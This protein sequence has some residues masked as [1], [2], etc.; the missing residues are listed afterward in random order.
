MNLWMLLGIVADIRQL[1][2]IWWWFTAAN[3]TAQIQAIDLVTKTTNS[4]SK[5]VLQ[6]A[7]WSLW[8]FTWAV[9]WFWYNWYNTTYRAYTDYITL[10][11][12]TMNSLDKGAS[13]RAI[14]WWGSISGTT[15]GW[16]LWWYNGANQPFIEYLNLTTTTWW[17]TN[18]SWTYYW[19]PSYKMADLSWTA[20][21]SV[22]VYWFWL[23]GYSNSASRAFISK[24]DMTTVTNSWSNV[25][26]LTQ[27][28]NSF[29]STMPAWLVYWFFIWAWTTPYLACDYL[30][31]ATATQNSIDKWNC[32][33][34]RQGWACTW[35]SEW[36][37]IISNS[38]Y[39]TS[40]EYINLTTTTGWATSW[41]TSSIGCSIAAWVW[42]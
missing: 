4:S 7:R 41:W 12:E 32:Q 23:G 33:I 31:L 3:Y 36:G 40:I 26:N 25:W 10:T 34:A 21:Q 14:K 30:T 19:T 18:S 27:A 16:Y 8:G 1:G 29:W 5:W 22:S 11:S 13:S 20:R 35:N 6:N 37:Y 24:L 38:S 17:S 42:A 2:Y 39:S 9:Y 28:R 15:Y